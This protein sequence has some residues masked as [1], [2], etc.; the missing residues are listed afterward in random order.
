M[1]VCSLLKAFHV[2][3]A[4]HKVHYKGKEGGERGSAGHSGTHPKDRK[5]IVLD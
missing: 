2:P 1:E 5:M 4:S 3:I